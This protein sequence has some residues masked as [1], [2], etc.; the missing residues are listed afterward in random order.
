MDAGSVIGIVVPMIVDAFAAVENILLVVVKCFIVDKGAIISVV[1][2]IKVVTDLGIVIVVPIRVDV[3]LVIKS[4][5]MRRYIL[6]L[7]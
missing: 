6:S 5:F 7:N 3:K 1:D 2:S 4:I